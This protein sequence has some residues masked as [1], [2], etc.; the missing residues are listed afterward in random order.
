[1]T[2]PLY[3]HSKNMKNGQL[4]YFIS[5]SLPDSLIKQYLQEA[6]LNKGIL[7]LRGISPNTNVHDFLLEKLLPLLQDPENPK[8]AYAN[9][10]IN[11]NLFV[12]YNIT[13]VPTLVYSLEPN[14]PSSVLN[15]QVAPKNLYWKVAG[16][17]SGIWAIE[18]FATLYKSSAYVRAQNLE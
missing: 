11:P 3:A 17:V 14:S 8:A 2:R 5:F 15:Y 10:E 13:Q 16:P 4:Y 7:V 18:Q 1:M 9:I 12:R 6:A